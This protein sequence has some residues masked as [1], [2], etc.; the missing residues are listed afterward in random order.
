MHRGISFETAKRWDIDG[1]GSAN[2]GQVIAQKVD[3][4]GVL[5]PVL[6]GSS[7]HFGS[8]LVFL[9]DQQTAESCL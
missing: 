2:A 8:T 4:H 9:W 7:E 3:Y 5:G 1:I 6:L